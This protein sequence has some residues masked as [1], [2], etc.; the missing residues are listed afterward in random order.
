MPELAVPDQGEEI[1]LTRGQETELPNEVAVGFTD[2]V[3]EYK[4]GAVSA[5]RLSVWA[6]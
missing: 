2:A 4:S 6:S 1:T 5:A 3:D